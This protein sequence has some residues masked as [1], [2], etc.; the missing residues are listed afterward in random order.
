MPNGAE[1][2]LAR[3]QHLGAKLNLPQHIQLGALRI[4]VEADEANARHLGWRRALDDVTHQPSP[5][6]REHDG[7]RREASV[8]L[9]FARKRRRGLPGCMSVEKSARQLAPSARVGGETVRRTR[10]AKLVAGKAR[11]DVGQVHPVAKQRVDLPLLRLARA[12]GHREDARQ[13][14]EPGLRERLEQ[15]AGRRGHASPASVNGISDVG[16]RR[17]YWIS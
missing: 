2:R 12:E 8:L 9:D 16:E 4:V 11:D 3:S 10:L 6:P 7:T 5:M 13:L 1:A 17:G 15:G 14:R